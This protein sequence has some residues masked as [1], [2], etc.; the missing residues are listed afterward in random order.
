[1]ILREASWSSLPRFLS[2]ES[3]SSTNTTDG[4][5]LRATEKRARTSFSPSPRYLLV[6]AEALMQKNVALLS[7]ATALARRVLPVPG[8]G[9]E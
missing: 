8:E 3:S 9:G 6:S 1:M 2:R 7:V 5:I 4:C